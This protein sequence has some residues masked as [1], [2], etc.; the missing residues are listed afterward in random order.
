M[1]EQLERLSDVA[2]SLSRYAVSRSRGREGVKGVEG[3]NDDLFTGL[4]LLI[5][6]K[7]PV[8][9]GIE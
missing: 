7:I 6:M 9:T 3:L 1:K 2:L 4:P 8:I 5:Y